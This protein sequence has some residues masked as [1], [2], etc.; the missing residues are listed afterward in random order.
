[1]QNFQELKCGISKRSC[2]ISR[3]L[4]FWPWMKF[5]RDVTYIILRNFQGWSFEL[6]E[7]SRGTEKN[8]KILIY[9][10]FFKNVCP[11]SPPLPLF[12][13]FF[14]WN[15]SF[16]PKQ[17]T[18]IGPM[19]HLPQKKHWPYIKTG[20]FHHF[21][22]FIIIIS[23]RKVHTTAFVIPAHWGEE[24]PRMGSKLDVPSVLL[25]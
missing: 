13:F 9:S 23:F 25:C 20:Y 3:G 21:H 10:R 5:P 17:L 7:I 14:F 12:F 24:Y 15:S 11:Q 1:M 22:V 19:Q 2:E 8:Q 16:L 6:C 18:W 4:G